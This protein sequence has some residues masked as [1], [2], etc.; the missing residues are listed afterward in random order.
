VGLDAPPALLSLQ[1]QIEAAV[2]GCGLPPEDKP[3]SP[4]ITL[5][6]LKTPAPP[7]AVRA[8]LDPRAA[9]AAGPFPVEAF[10]LFSSVLAPAGPT[11]TRELLV[12]LRSA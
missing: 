2:T 9:F 6:R 8:F 11:Y 4:H 1:R 12:P 3:F 10:A 5:A 7:P